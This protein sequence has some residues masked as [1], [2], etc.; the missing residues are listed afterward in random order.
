MLREAEYIHQG[1]HNPAQE[2]HDAE[3]VQELLDKHDPQNDKKNPQD[4]KK[5]F[6]DPRLEYHRHPPKVQADG[7]GS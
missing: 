3:L 4:V 2:P 7:V 6:D 1:G 5:G